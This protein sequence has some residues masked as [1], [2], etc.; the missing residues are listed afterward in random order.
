VLDTLRNNVRKLSWTL[1]LVIIAFIVLYIP[2]LVQGPA[3]VV[4]RVDGEPIYAEDYVSALEQ[5]SDYYR[6]MSG[7]DLPED[8]LQ[9]IQIEQIVLDQLVREKLM[10]AAA[11]EQ[12]LTVTPQEIRD[13]LMRYE[14]FRDI[15]GRWIG[16]AAYLRTLRNSGLDVE[17]FERQVQQD[18][19]VSKFTELISSGVTVTDTEIQEA[20]QRRNEQVQFDFLVVRPE[21]HEDEVA[22]SI[23]EAELRERFEA[24]EPE[25]RLPER[26]RISYA[27]L[28]T[29]AIREQIDIPEE[30]LRDEYE[31]RID[32]FTVPEQVQARHILFRLP[33]EPDEETVA[34]VRSEA[35]AVREEIRAGAD[36]AEMARNNSDDGPTASAGGDLGWFGRGRM[37]PEFEE[38][39]FS[40]EVGETSGLVRTPFGF[41]IIRVEGQRPEQVR[42]FEQVRGQIEQQL[43]AERAQQRVERLADDLRRAVL[44]RRDLEELAAE[45]DLA[46]QQSE[47]FT[48]EEGPEGISSAEVARQAFSLGRGRVAEPIEAPSGY[49]VF[50]VDEIVDAHV[51]DFEEA[52]AAVRAD[53]V[54]ARARER[55]AEVA[56]ELGERLDAG[57]TFDELATEAGAAVRSTELIPR[58]GAVPELGREPGLVLAAFDHSEGEAGGPVEVTPGHALFRVTA[59][60]QPD[61]SAFEEQ[62]ESLRQELLNQ[63]RNALFE[64]MMG[65]LRERYRVVQYPDVLERLSG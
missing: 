12:G 33:P 41:H 31:A 54:E 52:R 45:F 32:E 14:V 29:E 1:W 9:Q 23:T 43:A 5:Q 4:A 35:E 16:H 26:R 60:V 38:V 10:A 62:R 8:F 28:E 19:L 27:V 51:P 30:R 57:A 36:F 15:E 58:S 47:L 2:N 37:T 6:N 17:N 48:R 7:G 49:V 3:N 56:A 55:A 40:L 11:Q 59:H 42:S 13:W 25:Y 64:S 21:D 39:A 65:Q 22:G 34:E 24:N 20:Y 18:A 63:R 50:R 46:V 53:V 44:R 61:W